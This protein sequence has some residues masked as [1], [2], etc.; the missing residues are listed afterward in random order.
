MNGKS[1]PSKWEVTMSVRGNETVLELRSGQ[2][3]IQIG[4]EKYDTD[5]GVKALE[6]HYGLTSDVEVRTSRITER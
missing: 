6:H 1:I 3:Y 4:L 2:T 5:R